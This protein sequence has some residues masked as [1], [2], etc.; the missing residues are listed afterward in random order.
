MTAAHIRPGLSD[1]R[2][3]VAST[4]KVAEVKSMPCSVQELLE[5]LTMADVAVTCIRCNVRRG[6]RR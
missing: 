6:A 1:A 3:T 2:A 4:R 5:A